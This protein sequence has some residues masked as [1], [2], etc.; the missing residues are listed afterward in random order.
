MCSESRWESSETCNIDCIAPPVS[1]ETST[2]ILTPTQSTLFGELKGMEHDTYHCEDTY[3][4][5]KY[6]C[7]TL[8]RTESVWLEDILQRREN[9][10]LPF[11]LPG[12]GSIAVEFG[13]GLGQDSRNMAKLAGWTVTSIDVSP[14]AI[15][16]AKNATDKAMQGFGPAQIEFIAYDAFAMPKPSQPIDYFFDATVYCG[17]RHSHLARAYEV[18]SR[19]FTP[20]HTL[21]NIQCWRSESAEAHKIGKALHDMKTD[22]EPMFDILHSEPCEK[23]QGGDGWCF[24]MKLKDRDTREKI[25]KDRLA[26][27]HAARDGDFGYIQAEWQKRPGKIS[28]EEYWTLASIARDRGHQWPMLSIIGQETANSKHHLIHPWEESA[29]LSYGEDMM[30]LEVVVSEDK[31]DAESHHER[32]ELARIR[33]DWETAEIRKTIQDLLSLEPWTSAEKVG[34]SLV[35]E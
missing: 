11:E 12:R 10:T 5:D 16:K 29:F 1:N 30:G 19:L 18:Y 17:M 22:F 3:D 7:S 24:Y 25:L 6:S 23:N 34:D 20:G 15:E 27:Q 35:E 4:D 26:L 28:E 2:K 33:R 13:C 9:G 32:M 21:I 14:S 31:F 8:S